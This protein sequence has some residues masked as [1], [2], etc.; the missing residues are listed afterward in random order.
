MGNAF[1]DT[2]P[3]LYL[4]GKIEGN[5]LVEAAWS[6]STLALIYLDC[7][8]GDPPVLAGYKGE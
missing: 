8:E 7:E 1:P 2:V 4:D 5:P 3:L 6:P